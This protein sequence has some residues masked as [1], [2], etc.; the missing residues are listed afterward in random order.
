MN[1]TIQHVTGL[2]IDT[3]NTVLIYL[4]FNLTLVFTYNSQLKG[5]PMNIKENLNNCLAQISAGIT[6]VL[7]TGGSASMLASAHKI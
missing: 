4:F 6:V 7:V 2:P 3:I 1:V 5:V